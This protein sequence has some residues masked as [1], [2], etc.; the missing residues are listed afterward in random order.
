MPID[1]SSAS[2]IIRSAL[3]EWGLSSLGDKA[4]EFLKAGDNADVVVIKLRETNEYKK[5]FAA[6]EDRRRKGM[7]VLSEAEYISAE[8]SYRQAMR[9]YGLPEGFYDSTED[10]QQFLSNDVSPQELQ[11]RV[12][13]AAENYLYASTEVKDQFARAGL[14]PGQAIASILDPDRALPLVRQQTTAYGL[15]GEAARAFSNRN[16]ISLD[17]AMELS[18][19]GVTQDQARKGFGELAGR[20][21]RDQFLAQLSGDALSERDLQNEVFLG[22]QATAQRRNRAL[23]QERGRFQGSY[24]SNE[25]GLTRTSGGSY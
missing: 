25:T 17:R 21:E 13:M 18:Q 8:Q 22:D 10:F 16:A 6:N 7:N 19:Q 1:W 15:A 23:A 2:A 5:R 11:D 4:D 9:K 14:T 24:V 12:A 20:Q 3:A